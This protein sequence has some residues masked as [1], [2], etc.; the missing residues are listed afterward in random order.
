MPPS[1]NAAPTNHCSLPVACIATCSNYRAIDQP[2]SPPNRPS[3]STRPLTKERLQVLPRHPS[4]IRRCVRLELFPTRQRSN[5]DRLEPGVAHET[6]G[7]IERLLIVARERNADAITLAMG[8]TLEH[9]EIDGV[10][11]FHPARAGKHP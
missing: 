11:C 10:E 4:V 6:G 8:F 9:L 7:D 1:S 5:H 3:P 2:E